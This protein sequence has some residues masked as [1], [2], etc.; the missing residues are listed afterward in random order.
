MIKFF[1]SPMNSGKTA[2]AL[3]AAHQFQEAG[4][5]VKLL[6]SGDRSKSAKIT[7]RL[8]NLSVDCTLY[9]RATKMYSLFW[10]IYSEDPPADL[11]IIDEAQF[12]TLSQVEGLVALDEEYDIDIRCY[13][14]L[15]D[16]RSELFPGS[17][18]LVELADEVIKLQ[19]DSLCWCA[20]P[21]RFN[22]RIVDGELVM[23]GEQIVVGD[24]GLD[25]LYV[26]LCRKHYLE[27]QWQKV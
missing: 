13:G 4:K 15:T 19:M 7:S 2:T 23:E 3:Q 8:G 20:S 5:T 6:T 17:K 1:Y 16:F 24:V 14:L 9:T 12:L 11:L 10:K 21:A 22:A 26:V 25:S 27:G 18:R